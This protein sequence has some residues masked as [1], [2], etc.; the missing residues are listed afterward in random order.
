MNSLCKTNPLNA[1]QK[2]VDNRLG[3]KNIKIWSWLCN[4]SW[5]NSSCLKLLFLK[6][7]Q[8]QLRWGCCCSVLHR[9]LEWCRCMRALSATYPHGSPGGPCWRG[10]RKPELYFWLRQG[11]GV[12][13]G[14]RHSASPWL[15]FLSCLCRLHTSQAEFS[16]CLVLN[17]Y[18]SSL[19]GCGP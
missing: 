7:V 1:I 11:P 8:T 10:L 15:R 18:F 9:C 2:R 19:K 14:E 5:P 17:V 16:L 13:P 6:R 3:V 12:W 4:A